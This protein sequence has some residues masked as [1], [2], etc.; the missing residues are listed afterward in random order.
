MKDPRHA[1]AF[2]RTRQTFLATEL[3]VADT[4]W[5][6][7]RGLLG[8]RA[9]EFTFG[10][11]LWIIPCRGVHTWAMRYPLDIVYLN[12]N[13]V[14]VHVDENVPPWRIT[15]MRMD[16]ETVLELPAHTV[17]N[18]STRVGDQI[19]ITFSKTAKQSVVA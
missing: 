12:D 6:R 19:E 4:Q 7:L 15:R 1:Y 16:T 5:R 17:W 14:V 2:N 11:G 10:K 9:E 8:T 13:D 3:R 18:T